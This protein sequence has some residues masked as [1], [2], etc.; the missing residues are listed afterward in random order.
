MTITPRATTAT[1][2]QAKFFDYA[3]AANPL[4][5]PD[6]P[7]S[8]SS[9]SASFFDEP[10][11][12][13]QPLDLSADLNCEGRPPV[14]RSAEIS[15]PG[16]RI[17]AP[18]RMRPASSSSL[19]EAMGEPKPVVGSST[20]RAIRSCFP[21]AGKPSTAAKPAQPLLGA[22]CP[23]ASISGREHREAGVRTCF[24]SH[25]DAARSWMRSPAIPAEPMPIASACSWG[26][27]FPQTHTVTHTLW[28]M[29]G[30]L[31][32]GQVQRPHRHQSIALDL[33]WLANRAVAVIGAELDENGLIRNGHRED[34]WPVQHRDPRL[35]ALP[36][37][38]VRRRRL[39][40]AHSGCRSSRI[41][42]RS[43]L[44]SATGAGVT[45]ER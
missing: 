15:S 7:D 34:G 27:A 10:G 21:L 26:N 5:R 35:L 43:T 39:R 4:E 29:L 11:T 25:Q 38:R 40:A 1:S 6:R 37:Q 33:R 23:P 19:P 41:S 31:P 28:A 2:T 16:A 13:L 3:S 32:A 36:P 22:R 24:Y 12:A 9:F 14:H 44:P 17:T 45:L 20:G 30:I 42:A 8:L 18:M